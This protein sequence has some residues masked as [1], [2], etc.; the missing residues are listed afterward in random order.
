MILLIDIGGTNIKYG[1]MDP[2]S[3][4]FE[5][6]SEMPTNT[7]VDNFKMEERLFD[8]IS[9][10]QITKNIEGIAISSAGI[11]NA[12]TGEIVYANKN[13]PNYCGTKIKKILENKYSVPV[14][15]ENDVNSALMG[16]IHF[17]NHG[18]IHSALMLTIGTGVGGAIYINDDIYHGYTH[19]AGE[20]GYSVLNGEN[21][22]EVASTTALVNNVK[23][24]I[25]QENVDGHW[26]FDQAINKGNS[27]CEE[28]IERLIRN[29]VIFIS[30]QVA[31]LNPQLVILGGG[32]MEQKEFLKP[33]INHYFDKIITN[34]FIKDN[35]NIEF[36]SLGNDAGLLGAYKVFENKYFK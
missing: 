16:E 25:N 24:R 18:D 8:L 27:V 17:G 33:I 10:V 36:A 13:I 26:I 32:I 30:N 7:H 14:S 1:S 11:V 2:K 31:L 20:V 15:I 22:E 4:I 19:S 28:E 12:E 23:K 34:E 6:I 3:L 5:K 35:T 29:I 21:I 9:D